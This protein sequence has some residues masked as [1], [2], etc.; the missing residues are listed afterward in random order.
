MFDYNNFDLKEE[1]SKIKAITMKERAQDIFYLEKYTRFKFGQEGVTKVYQ[2]LKDNGFELPD[3]SG[4]D[5][6]DWM[7]ATIPTAY[8]VGMVKAFNWN[9]DNIFEMGRQLRSMSPMLKLIMKHFISLKHSVSSATK[10]WNTLYTEG[11]MELAEF[12]EK[13]K[14]IVYQL[15]DFA[16]HPVTCRYILGVATGLIELSV[17]ETVR[18]SE[19]KCTFKGDDYHE[20]VFTWE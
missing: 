15:K 11:K 2:L 17:H 16:K 4:H 10:K 3:I 19:N 14:R 9:E 1:L 18:S 12:D 13:N 20:F 8:M 6:M 5:P 7:P